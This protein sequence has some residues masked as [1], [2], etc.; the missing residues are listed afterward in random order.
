MIERARLAAGLTQAEL[1]ER[2]RTTQSAIARVERAGSNPTVD[3]LTRVVEAAGS[4]LRL[5]LDDRPEQLDE[6]QVREFMRR[7]PAE[8]LRVHD[9]SRQNVVAFAKA[10]RRVPE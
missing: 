4:R 2:L 8:R 5:D 9:A 10:A 6:G 1:A 3:Y 7:T